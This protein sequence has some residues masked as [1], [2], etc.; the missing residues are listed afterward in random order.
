MM[1]KAR[2]LLM[3]LMKKTLKVQ[4]LYSPASGDVGAVGEKCDGA[5]GVGVRPARD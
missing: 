3:K 2:D 4:V 5:E 1:M